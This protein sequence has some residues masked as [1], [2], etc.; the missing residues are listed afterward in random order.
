M[1]GTYK[2]TLGNA[3]LS[4]GVGIVYVVGVVVCT[5]LALVCVTGRKVLEQGEKLAEKGQCYTAGKAT[6]N[7]VQAG[8]DVKEAYGIYK[9]RKLEAT[10]EEKVELIDEGYSSGSEGDGLKLSSSKKATD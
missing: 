7:F 2:Q 4:V 9:Q 6:E 3:A 10:K 1:N 8:S 5:A